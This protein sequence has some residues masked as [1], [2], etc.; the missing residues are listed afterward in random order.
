[1][2]AQETILEVR[3][4]VEIPAATLHTIVENAKKLS[5]LNEK[6]YYEVDTADRVSKLISRF[7]VEKDFH[8][9]IENLDHYTP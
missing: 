7:L 4:N 6:G 2:R 8:S 3:V 1:M 9:F 5:G